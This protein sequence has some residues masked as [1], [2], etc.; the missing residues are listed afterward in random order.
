MLCCEIKPL[1]D[2]VAKQDRSLAKQLRE[3]AT[4]VALNIGEAARSRAGHERERFGT[5]A[6][7][8]SDTRSAL[9]VAAAWGYI[10]NEDR[11][12]VDDKLDRIAA[13]LWRHTH[14]G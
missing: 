4:S 10:N 8:A 12:P 1:I 11:M 3:S 2:R 6:G 9:E 7:S 14:R 13:M 5:A